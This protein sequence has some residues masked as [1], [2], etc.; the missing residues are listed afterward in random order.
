MLGQSMTASVNL[1][2]AYGCAGKYISLPAEAG[3]PQS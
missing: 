1:R 2:S 3:L